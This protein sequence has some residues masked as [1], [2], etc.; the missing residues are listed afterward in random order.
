M[1]KVAVLSILCLFFI[2]YSCNDEKKSSNESNLIETTKSENLPSSTDEEKVK[3]AE[4]VNADQSQEIK[5]EETQESLEKV[6]PSKNPS[7]D[8]N[9]GEGKFTN[10]K[11]EK[12]LNVKFAEAGSE[13]YDVKCASCHKLTDE[14]LV[15]PGWA[16]VTKRRHPG[17]IMNFMSNPDVMLDKDPAAKE[18]LE[19]CAV[20]MPN[21]NLSDEEMR[22][23]LE[24]MRKNDGVR[25]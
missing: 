13:A 8:P 22:N 10:V 1:K 20:R 5:K 2:T 24:F 15:G 16:G 4:V 14:K 9:R 21:Q 18:M 23:L 11:I 3:S 17:W 7:Y 6:E 19:L 12:K 25:P